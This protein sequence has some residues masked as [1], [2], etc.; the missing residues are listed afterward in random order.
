MSKITKYILS[1]DQ[2]TTSSR[3][4]LFDENYEIISIGQREFTQF[5]PD[6]GL[7]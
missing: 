4:V 3:G 5:F 6:S 2:G 7:G 1:I